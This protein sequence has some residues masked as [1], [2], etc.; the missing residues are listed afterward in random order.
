MAAYFVQI[1]ETAAAFAALKKDWHALETKSRNSIPFR[2]FEWL[3]SWWRHFP[4]HRFAVTDHLLTHIVREPEGSPVLAAPMMITER[5][6]KGPV[7]IRILQFFGTDPN[8]TELRGPLC[9]P[10]HESDAHRALREHVSRQRQEHRLDRV[11]RRDAGSA[12][13]S[14]LEHDR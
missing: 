14:E 7:R 6:S 5:P 9:D 4:E 2:T 12:A 3:D 10:D 8:I 11:E 13:E 1:I